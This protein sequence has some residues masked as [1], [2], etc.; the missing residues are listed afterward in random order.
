MADVAPH[1]KHV[2]S[3]W[4]PKDRRTVYRQCLIHGCP[5]TE[6]KDVSRA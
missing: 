5:A 4:Y 6:D 3:R 1:D 2:W